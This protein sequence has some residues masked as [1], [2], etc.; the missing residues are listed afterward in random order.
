MT[1]SRDRVRIGR[2]IDKLKKSEFGASD[3]EDIN[4]RVETAEKKLLM[5]VIDSS[6]HVLLD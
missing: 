3:A 5:S 1:N 6:F 2:V 4:T